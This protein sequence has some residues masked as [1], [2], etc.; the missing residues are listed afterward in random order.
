MDF[1]T[2]RSV[3][4]QLAGTT[5]PA[6][7]ALASPGVTLA[8]IN[9]FA[10][11]SFLLTQNTGPFWIGLND[12]TSEGF[13]TWD[14]FAFGATEFMP[15]PWVNGV[16]S[17]SNCGSGC[18]EDCVHWMPADHFWNDNSCA[19]TA[20]APLNCGRLLRAT[21]DGR[22]FICFF[23]PTWP[24]CGGSTNPC[25]TQSIGAVCEVK[26]CDDADTLGTGLPDGTC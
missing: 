16:P 18:T 24:G 4:A 14:G 7:S 22:L 25:T 8:K 11:R 26:Q 9:D 5:Y 17:N 10:E 2:A 21:A 13:Y 15:R 3:C 12:I 23:I 6:G 19:A 20:V 1:Q